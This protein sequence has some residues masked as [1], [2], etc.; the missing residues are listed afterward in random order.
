MDSYV[1]LMLEAE[2]AKERLQ[3]VF[4]STPEVKKNE[5]LHSVR[6]ASADRLGVNVI[7]L[8]Q[9]RAVK[10][11]MAQNRKRFALWRLS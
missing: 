7:P 3:I 2:G 6:N 8:V 9:S 4:Q 1:S 11:A 5:L 10:Q